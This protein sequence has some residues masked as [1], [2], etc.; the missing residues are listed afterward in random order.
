MTS[1]LHG[2]FGPFRAV[3]ARTDDAENRRRYRVRVLGIH[4][5]QSD[6]DMLPWAETSAFG[7]KYFG[8][9]PRLAVG[10]RVWVQFEGGDRR[11][12]VITGSWLTAPSGVSDIPT[13]LSNLASKRW[14]RLD[15]AGNLIEM[16]ENEEEL[17]IK[18]QSGGAEIILSQKD[19]TV[20]L[21]ADT[22]VRV[23]APYIEADGDE[24]TVTARI[25]RVETTESATIRSEQTIVAHAK[26]RIEI[27]PY[28]DALFAAHTTPEVLVDGEELVQ[29]ESRNRVFAHSEKE[30]DLYSDDNVTL[31]AKTLVLIRATEARVRVEA[32]Y[33]ES[34]AQ[35]S[36]HIEAPS[37]TVDATNSMVVTA[38]S[39]QLTVENDATVVVQG[40]S[41]VTVQGNASMTVAGALDIASSGALS[42]TAATTL[43]LNAA[44]IECTAATKFQ[45]IAGANV[46]LDAPILLVGV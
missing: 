43:V 23:E 42:L 34:I 8:D 18:F 37:V 9:I 28:T 24:V 14:V 30:L 25:A 29:L 40:N 10:D 6:D 31:D 36:A 15:R 12:P 2:W 38:A 1:G 46:V 26:E 7:G 17:H 13:E 44:N 32:D 45:A 4:L 5:P 35:I 21:R 39:L 22:R 11:Y 33:I 20:S 27:G 41:S 3:V 16:S 19:D